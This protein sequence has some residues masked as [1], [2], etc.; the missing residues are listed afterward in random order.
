M[1]DRSLKCIITL[2]ALMLAACASIEQEA[3][4]VTPS[5]G[6]VL[7]AF[8]QPYNTGASEGIYYELE[9][10]DPIRAAAQGVVIFARDWSPVGTMI[11]ID[12][13]EGVHSFYSGRISLKAA[14]GDTVAKGQIIASGASAGDEKP[15]LSFEIRRK[16]EALDPGSLIAGL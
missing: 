9:S 15:V 12:H 16:G 4:L 10:G 1:R 3:N 6:T 8:G 14:E 2:A 13:T 7:A 11:V 5:D